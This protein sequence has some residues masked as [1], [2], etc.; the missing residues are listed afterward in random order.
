MWEAKSY[1]GMTTRG[2]EWNND[3]LSEV[4]YKNWLAMLVV[5]T[6]NKN[7]QLLE[8][9]VTKLLKETSK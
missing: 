9:Q 3:T 5:K 7:R 2:V 4:E 8:S 6:S 1:N